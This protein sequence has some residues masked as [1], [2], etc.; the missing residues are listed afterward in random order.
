MYL[1]VYAVIW[2]KDLIFDVN[3]FDLVLT[4]KF[5]RVAGDHFEN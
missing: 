1:L 2:V 5:D 4:F 3:L